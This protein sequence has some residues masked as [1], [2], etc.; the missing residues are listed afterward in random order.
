MIFME[1]LLVDVLVAALVSLGVWTVLEIL[2]TLF[3]RE[4]GRLAARI[5]PLP[6]GAVEISQYLN[7]LR[8][9]SPWQV[10]MALEVIGELFRI[11]IRELESLKYEEWKREVESQKE[12]M[13]RRGLS[14]DEIL[15]LEAGREMIQNSNNLNL[16]SGGG[17]YSSPEEEEFI[18]IRNHK[19]D[20][21]PDLRDK[22]SDFRIWALKNRDI[23]RYVQERVFRREELDLENLRDHS[24]EWALVNIWGMEPPESYSEDEILEDILLYIEIKDDNIISKFAHALS[25]HS[26]S[27]RYL[28]KVISAV[29]AWK[30]GG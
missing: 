2:P 10:F 16:K 30:R 23:L 1:A 13:E 20:L 26:D 12:R 11:K 25:S 19:K 22:Y 27:L 18:R 8:R 9:G 21:L 29:S 14:D 7:L 15:H 17:L 5:R 24:R 28:D 6:S 3:P 4:T